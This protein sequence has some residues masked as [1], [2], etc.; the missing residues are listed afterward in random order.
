MHRGWWRDREQKDQSSPVMVTVEAV[1]ALHTRGAASGR[2]VV[3]GA[4]SR[5][6]CLGRV[7]DM[8]QGTPRIRRRQTCQRPP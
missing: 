6:P 7:V 2:D 5:M 8:V 1:V 4:G 3:Q